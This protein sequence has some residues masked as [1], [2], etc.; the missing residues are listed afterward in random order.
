MVTESSLVV[1]DVNLAAVADVASMEFGY[2]DSVE[3]EASEYDPQQFVS[4]I[5]CF[6]SA[7]GSRV[8]VVYLRQYVCLEPWASQIDSIV[9]SILEDCASFHEF[10]FY[11]L[12][13]MELERYTKR[14]A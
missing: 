7:L 3:K 12:K 14:Q 6:N 4:M 2:A 1:P 11:Q 9:A 5:I 8:S 13:Q 10:H